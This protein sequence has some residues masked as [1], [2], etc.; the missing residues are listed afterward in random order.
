MWKE[1]DAQNVKKYI[2]IEIW[3]K[4]L[5]F[6]KTPDM[7]KALKVRCIGLGN[8]TSSLDTIKKG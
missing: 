1:L 8:H 4:Q 2:Y 7:L 6:D 3:S 5:K